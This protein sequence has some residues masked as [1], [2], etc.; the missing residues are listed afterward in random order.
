MHIFNLIYKGGWKF[1]LLAL[2]FLCTD[3]AAQT[4][5]KNG[6]ELSLPISRKKIVI[7]HCMTNII[8]YKGH[9]FEDSCNPAY[10][11]STG[12]ITAPIG[13][14]TQVWPMEDSLLKD[15]P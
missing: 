15:A 4:L 7:A 2:N 6:G 5:Q 13:G 8:R 1:L 10:Y 9:K 11:S 14:L 12:N 3:I